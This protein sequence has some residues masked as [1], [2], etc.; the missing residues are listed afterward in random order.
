MA[1]QINQEAVRYGTKSKSVYIFLELAGAPVTG[2]A[3]NTAGIL[4][5]YAG[6]KLAR[7]AI[8]PVTLAAITTA[9]TSGG[10]KELDATNM[11]GWYRLDVP[12]AAFSLNADAVI[13]SIFKSTAFHGSVR[14]PLAYKI[15]SDIVGGPTVVDARTVRTNA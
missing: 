15:E 14:I 3:F 11:P 7:V 1:M 10:F 6:E 13:I 5:S 12:D 9:W 4:A 8:T 2:V